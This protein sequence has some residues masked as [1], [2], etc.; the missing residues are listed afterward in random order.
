[1]KIRK[2]IILI[3]ISNV[4]LSCASLK[5]TK[6]NSNDISISIKETERI[7]NI[8]A[9]DEFGGREVFS[10]DIEKASRFIETE[11]EKTGLDYFPGFNSFR[12]E[13]I[14]NNKKA[15]NVVGYIKGKSKPDEY[16]LFSAHYDH[17]GKLNNV[18]KN[19][20]MDTVFN[21]ANDNASGTT[22]V[23]QL[24]EYFK[25]NISNERSI[26]F[27]AFTGEESG[28]YGAR[29]LSRKIN[30]DKIVAMF[31]LEMIGTKSKWGKNS[32]FITGYEM[33]D[34]GTIL[35]KS[36][37]GN[38][39]RFYKDPYPDESLFYRSDNA[40][41]AELGVPAHT[42]CTAKMDN[43][44]FYHKVN[45]EVKTLDLNNL[46]VI[47]KNIAFCSQS[48]ISGKNTPSRIKIEPGRITID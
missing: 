10:E 12:Q 19:T 8:L 33:T 13:F 26:I 7:I 9:S 4:L 23:I 48:I 39:F 37:Q 24:A 22:A 38:K 21:G 30:A 41:F 43:E 34:F 1:M 35:N 16:V 20:N 2:S 18:E 44:P 42:L 32:V 47:I 6:T 45:D 36:I 46:N 40:T 27:V 15:N 17:L 25:K 28:G 31:N 5:K 14:V 11:F 29:E 3:I